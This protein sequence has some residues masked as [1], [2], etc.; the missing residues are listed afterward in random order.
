[1]AGGCL[2]QWLPALEEVGCLPAKQ[3]DGEQ[4]CR[5]S[6][7][8]ATATVALALLGAVGLCWLTLSTNEAAVMT[9]RSGSSSFVTVEA[10]EGAYQRLPAVQ[11]GEEDAASEEG[12]A[13]DGGKK[14][15]AGALAVVAGT[16]TRPIRKPRAGSLSGSP[17]PKRPRSRPTTP[18]SFASIRCERACTHHWVKLHETIP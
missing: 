16:P 18:I 8:W 6:F 9:P 5:S 2:M 14:A 7:R 3:K 1:M 17:S 10:E 13:S 11:E 4:D 12:G 15:T